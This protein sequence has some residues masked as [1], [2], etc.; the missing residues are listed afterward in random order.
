MD[1]RGQGMKKA[2]SVA[3]ATIDLQRAFIAARPPGCKS[4]TFPMPYWGPGVTGT[5]YWYLQMPPPC[6]H[7][8]Q[9]VMA[10][11]WVEFSAEYE[12]R[13]EPYDT[14]SHREH[15]ARFAREIRPR[16][17]RLARG[18]LFRKAK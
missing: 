4:C 17:A 5:G 18:P 1:A 15:R 6:R 9:S 11:L 14:S 13:R 10:R 12:I 3:E 16:E 8:C 7:P 2:I